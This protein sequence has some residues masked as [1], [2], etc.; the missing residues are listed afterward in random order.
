MNNVI[1][2]FAMKYKG[3]WEKI[4]Y[5]IANKEPICYY[6]INKTN[7]K[8]ICFKT[9]ISKDYPDELKKIYKPPFILFVNGDKNLL[10]DPNKIGL[11]D[12]N[13]NDENAKEFV[14][15][16]KNIYILS[17]KSQKL[18]KK[19]LDLNIKMIVLLNKSHKILSKNPLYDL[20]IKKGNLIISELPNNSKLPINEEYFKRLHVGLSN[21]VL[22]IEK[23]N[24]DKEE[25][26]KIANKENIDVVSITSNRF[27]NFVIKK[28]NDISSIKF[29]VK[30]N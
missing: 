17:W 29:D 7:T 13:I 11:M 10:K 24:N 22:F 5:A 26:L 4:Y 21:K 1:L 8:N 16:N 19:L 6:D 3:D 28:I 14:K 27:K 30:K 2:F 9:I 23:I 12:S 18:I 15:N 20:L 25:Y